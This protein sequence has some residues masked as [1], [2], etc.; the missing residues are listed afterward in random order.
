[1]ISVFF[2]L[3]ERQYGYGDVLRNAPPG[4]MV[5][6]TGTVLHLA[7]EGAGDPFS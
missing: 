6:I 3:T 5:G 4:E 7:L 1:M 2:I